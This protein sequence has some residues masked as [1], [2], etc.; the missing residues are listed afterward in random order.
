LEVCELENLGETNT[1]CT[2]FFSQTIGIIW[3]RDQCV[4]IVEMKGTSNGIVQ[5]GRWIGVG[6]E[7][8]D[9]VLGLTGTSVV[10]AIS[11]WRMLDL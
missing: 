5:N 10:R 4:F 1:Q 7:G 3:T 2:G 6:T 9:N 8:V 11:L